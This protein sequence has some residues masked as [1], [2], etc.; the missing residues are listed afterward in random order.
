MSVAQSWGWWVARSPQA[1]QQQG[2]ELGGSGRSVYGHKACQHHVTWHGLAA[3]V[4]SCV[5]GSG[6]VGHRAYQVLWTLR[7]PALQSNGCGG[8]LMDYAFEYVL[9]NGGLDTELDYP[10]WSWDLPCQHR[11]E[12]HRW[13]RAGLVGPATS[14]SGIKV[15]VVG[16]E[17]S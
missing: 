6:G 3:W 15:S 5:E 1:S 2:R 14:C 7:V 10:Y 16:L 11:R 9:K 13:V 12:E 4:L 17:L 8:G